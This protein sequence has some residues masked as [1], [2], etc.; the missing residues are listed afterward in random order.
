MA[1]NS[2][3]F[4]FDKATAELVP[5]RDF[6]DFVNAQVGVYMDCLSSFQGNAVRIERQV[7]RVNRPRL[8]MKDGHPVMIMESFEDPSRPDAIHHRIIAATDFLKAN[9]DGGF[10][11]RQICWSIIVFMFAYWDEEIRPQIAKIREI[12]PN[13]LKVDTLGDLRI[14]R[15]SI[16]HNKGILTH[17]DY[18]KIKELGDLVQPEKRIALSHDDMQKLFARIK[19]A[20]A[21][22]LL[23]KT[24]GIPGAPDPSDIASVTIQ[25]AGHRKSWPYDDD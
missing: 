14:L 22:L 1:L 19:K 21:V 7:A 18:S 13:E 9:R 25:N 24:K 4:D 11:H 17:T 16:V 10:S 2:Q 20:I 3:G 5:L 23:E 6:I 8:G 12:E 15:K